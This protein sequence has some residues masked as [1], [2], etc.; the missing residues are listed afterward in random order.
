[1]VKRSRR[2]EIPCDLNEN[3]LLSGL[4]TLEV[5]IRYFKFN[6]DIHRID[7]NTSLRDYNRPYYEENET[8]KVRGRFVKCYSSILKL[9]QMITVDGTVSYITFEYNMDEK[10][11]YLLLTDS[12]AVCHVKLLKVRI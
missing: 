11:M 2:I 1:M 12:Y 4:I 6:P 8:Q 5:G 10:K 9:E 3:I 7:E